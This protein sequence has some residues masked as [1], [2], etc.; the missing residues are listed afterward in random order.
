MRSN[1]SD[2]NLVVE[3]GESSR[4]ARKKSEAPESK[5]KSSPEKA[6]IPDSAIATVEQRIQVLDLQ[7]RN[8]VSTDITLNTFKAY[9][10]AIAT[11]VSLYWLVADRERML[12]CDTLIDSFL[13]TGFFAN[14]LIKTSL[15]VGL[16][17]ALYFLLSFLLNWLESTTIADK[18]LEKIAIKKVSDMPIASR[19]LTYGE[20]QAEIESIKRFETAKGA[21]FYNSALYFSFI[22]GHF[23]PI[24]ALINVGKS[25]SSSFQIMSLSY[26]CRFEQA[27][28][29]ASANYSGN[30]AL[31]SR[32]KMSAVFFE[33]LEAAFPN[34]SLTRFP[35][36]SVSFNVI[37]KMMC[38]IKFHILSNYLAF[39]V[40]DAGKTKEAQYNQLQ[41]SYVIKKI[42]DVEIAA[43]DAISMLCFLPKEEVLTEENKRLASKLYT[44]RIKSLKKAHTLRGSLYECLSLFLQDVPDTKIKSY[45]V[46]DRNTHPIF[47]F[48]IKFSEGYLTE[49]KKEELILI[50]CN[51]LRNDIKDIENYIYFT[52]DY[53]NFE[54]PKPSAPIKGLYENISKLNEFF[55][56]KNS[57]DTPL[58]TGSSGLEVET[59][60]Q[61]N[62]KRTPQV[63]LAKISAKSH[64]NFFGQGSVK[65]LPKDIGIEFNH[66]KYNLG[67]A[68]CPLYP[69]YHPCSNRP[70]AYVY[71]SVREDECADGKS[72][73]HFLAQIKEDHPS[74]NN[75]ST[76]R[77]IKQIFNQ[78]AQKLKKEKLGIFKRIGFEDFNASDIYCK[79]HTASQDRAYCFLVGKAL[80]ISS[81]G[82]AR[83]INIL[84]LNSVDFLS[85]N[86][87]SASGIVVAKEDGLKTHSGWQLRTFLQ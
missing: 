51:A 57:S 36:S 76:G 8:S 12:F 31:S 1:D 4:W 29:N 77:G 56:G 46:D 83:S 58:L 67:A 42:Y 15:G 32:K 59:N 34:I 54:F 84:N 16:G 48:S 62:P 13:P 82:K 45:Y 49:A 35:D 2:D 72:I 17:N 68:D 10:I 87:S 24:Y 18:M 85:H 22:M 19:D 69:L 70:I 39:K 75:H 30:R 21:S 5:E 43:F 37:E 9:F 86:K 44:Q 26:L 23:H 7:I 52:Q 73:S 6:Q 3:A 27:G 11:H 74:I 78:E 47:D 71:C 38:E 79:L 50:I 60:T 66:Q 14:R 40:S 81:D 55:L 53:L 20:V 65:A 64:P 80:V 28:R 63:K 61:S 25:F 41:L 33:H